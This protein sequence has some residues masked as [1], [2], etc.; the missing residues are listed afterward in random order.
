M[1]IIC[2]NPAI[3]NLK[4]RFHYKKDVCKANNMQKR[5]NLRSK[6]SMA[7]PVKKIDKQTGMDVVLLDS[8]TIDNFRNKIFPHIESSLI[9]K[10]NVDGIEINASD[11]FKKVSMRDRNGN[12]V[13]INYEENEELKSILDT[14]ATEIE[15]F[16]IDNMES[17]VLANTKST[18]HTVFGDMI[19]KVN[20]PGE[21]KNADEVTETFVAPFPPAS[22]PEKGHTVRDV[23]EELAYN[24]IHEVFENSFKKAPKNDQ[25][26]EAVQLQKTHEGVFSIIRNGEIE[27]KHLPKDKDLLVSLTSYEEWDKNFELNIE[28]HNGANSGGWTSAVFD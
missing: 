12:T 15:N 27:W 3:C 17:D 14:K 19:V 11:L 1:K 26:I 21:R 16:Y 4:G 5:E 7:P 28:Y 6:A 18:E 13:D 22:N 20:N 10:F 9:G 2:P 24:N 25:G 23:L 8:P